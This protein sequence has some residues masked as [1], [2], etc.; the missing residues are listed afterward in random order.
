MLLPSTWMRRCQVHPDVFSRYSLFFF[1]RQRFTSTCRGERRQLSC[2]FILP[3]SGEVGGGGGGN[4]KRWA[5]PKFTSA[6]SEEQE[7]QLLGQDARY[8]GK[9]S[10]GPFYEIHVLFVAVFFSFL[11]FFFSLTNSNCCMRTRKNSL[12]VHPSLRP[13]RAHYCVCSV[14]RFQ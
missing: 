2:S 9:S 5:V 6:R 12:R 7:S 8:C 3:A 1:R 4:M 14:M 10:W 13:P 11:F